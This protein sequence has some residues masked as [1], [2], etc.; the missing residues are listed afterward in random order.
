MLST[1]ETKK[2]HSIAGIFRLFIWTFQVL[3]PV[4][5][6]NCQS[7]ST[8]SA[9]SVR[10]LWVGKY[11]SYHK[12]VQLWQKDEHLVQGITERMR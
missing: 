7:P 2:Q 12:K 5:Q 3:L 11:W 6:L 10:T 9:F 8:S 1:V 4:R